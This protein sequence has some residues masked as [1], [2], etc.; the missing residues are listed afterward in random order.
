[1]LGTWFSVFGRGFARFWRLV[2][3][4]CRV[5][6]NLVVLALVALLVY[7]W[8]S[9]G[10]P[11]LLAKTALVLDL[12][13]TIVEQRAAGSPAE[14]LQRQALGQATAQVQLR[15]LLTVLDAASRDAKIAHAVLRLDDFA[16]AG[17]PTLREAAAAIQRFKA[18]G[19]KVVAWGAG[20]DQRQYYLAAHADEV[21][22]HPM[23]RVEIE[24]FGRHRTYYRDLLERAGVSAH[25]IRVGRFKNAAEPYVASAPSPE[26]LEAERL[27]WDGMWTSYTAGVEAARGLPQGSLARGIDE[28]P[29]RLAAVAGDTARL[30]LEARL[31]DGLKTADELRELLIE[32]GAR[33]DELKSF[34]QTSFRD[35]LA[36]QKP[37]SSGDAVGVIVAEGE[38]IDG[39]AP[40]G[41]VGGRST[42]DLI[43]RARD[44]KQVKAI[45]LRVDSPGGSAFGSELVRRELELTRAAGKPV[46]VSMG[47]VAASGGYWISMAADEVI[48][49][50]A[51]ITGSIGV[52]AL[53]PTAERALD[54]VGV[55]TGGYTTTWLAGAYD[56]RR[57]L[58]ERF[59]GVVQQAVNRIYADFTAKA[60]AARK[61]TPERIDA[62]G[63]GRVWTGRQALERGLVDRVGSFGDALGAA[64]TRAGLDEGYRVAYLEREPG[65]FE[66]VLSMLGDTAS[67]V[68]DRPVDLAAWLAGPPVPAAREVRED[69]AW[70]AGI[71][72]RREPFAAIAHCLCGE[73]W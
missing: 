64:A 6:V 40:P 23:G 9:S 30:A 2:D 7:A 60:A 73:R 42:A 57:P 66:R 28:L 55:A 43:R 4:G 46:V 61:V 10:P 14:R 37:A 69:L 18:S 52:F 29:E 48:A 12:R 22:L 16:G 20:Y 65:R 47:D 13:G 54:K 34:R 3:A 21:Y 58:D 71:A 33:D 27:L 50:E 24:G 68:A 19:K 32:R 5:V 31:V 41:R 15:D 63:E 8:A 35:Y 49:D 38:I 56:P 11:R 39:S 53:L 45:V 1:M 72:D 44:D 25:L 67:R 36:R 62:V 17:L 51:T 70:L 59:A 26:S